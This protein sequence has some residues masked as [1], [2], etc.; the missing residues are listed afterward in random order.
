MTDK[1][2]QSLAKKRPLIH[3]ITNPIS[4]NQC[5]NAILAVGARPMMAEHPQEAGIIT[6]TAGALM[7]NLGNFNDVRAQ[8]ML[9]SAQTASEKGIPFLLDVCGAACL[10]NRRDYALSLIEKYRPTVIK[11]NRSEIAALYDESYT[12]TGV[13]SAE[14]MT[15]ERSDKA[16]AAL[17][18]QTGCVVIASGSIDTVTDGRRITHIKNGT[19]RMGT[20]TG[21][22]CMQ[23]AVCAAFL[24]VCDAFSA[25]VSACVVLG[26][27]GELAE[28]VRGSGS[29]A[30]AL[31]DGI[32]ELDDKDIAPHL[33]LEETQLEQA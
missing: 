25:A 6:A 31:M 18:R 1:I 32:S 10:K 28:S 26:V 33:K 29:F 2:R 11:G 20:V 30:V 9:I 27:S 5:A 15:A 3:C 13:D 22:G 12:S 24:S 16:A 17:A 4:I 7:L 14:D 8:S 19:P 21:T 23:G